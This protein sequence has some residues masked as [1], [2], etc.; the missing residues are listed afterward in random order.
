MVIF[1]F[2]SRSP[3]ASASSLAPGIVSVNVPA[4]TMIVFDPLWASAAM[5]ADR[6]EMCPLES[7]PFLRLT[8]TRVEGRVHPERRKL[9]PF[10]QRFQNRAPP[11]G[12]MLPATD[13]SDEIK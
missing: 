12:L 2:T 3:V 1:P 13:S 7:L 8:A 6:S 9:D 4:G 11:R 10:F 5:M